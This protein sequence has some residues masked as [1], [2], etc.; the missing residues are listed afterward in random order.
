VS[1]RTSVPE[2]TP[3][4]TVAPDAP[5]LR[6]CHLDNTPHTLRVNWDTRTAHELRIGGPSRLSLHRRHAG[7]DAELI[8]GTAYT[9]AAVLT[10]AAGNTS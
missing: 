9:C 10:D 3:V 8:D 4:D 7:R 2:V 5:A 6:V 1:E